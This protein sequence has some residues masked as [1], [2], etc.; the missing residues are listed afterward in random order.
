MDVGGVELLAHALYLASIVGFMVGIQ[1]M[2]R[3]KTAL[4]GNH[5]AAL[6]M[7]LAIAGQLIENYHTLEPKA[8]LGHPWTMVF[9]LIVGAALGMVLAVRVKMT[10]MPEMVGLLNGL[11]GFASMIV[12]IATYAL[13]VHVATGGVGT[14]SE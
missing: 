1:R 7:A 9:G 3:V 6:A 5:L 10:Q 12:G 11:G 2:S 8:G 13:G 4:Q 14:M